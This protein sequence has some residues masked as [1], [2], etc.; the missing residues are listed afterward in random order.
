MPANGLQDRRIIVVSGAP[1]SQAL[2]VSVEASGGAVVPVAFD[3]Q[4]GPSPDELRVE[5]QAQPWLGRVAEATQGADVLLYA[6]AAWP[7]NDKDGAVVPFIETSIAGG[8]F[9]LKLAK[10]L[11]PQAAFDVVFA[12][13]SLGDGVEAARAADM[14][15]GASRQM[16]KTAAS[17]TGTLDPPMTASQLVVTGAGRAEALAPVLVRLIARPQGYISGTTISVAG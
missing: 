8:L 2:T 16:M 7:K 12:S 9:C 4:T 10:R 11:Q 5:D 6:G 1:L 17:E 13:G 3:G 14:W 15:Q